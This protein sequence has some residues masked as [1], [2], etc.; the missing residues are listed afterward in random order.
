MLSMPC[1]KFTWHSH[2][3]F[4]DISIQIFCPLMGCLSYCCKTC[5]LAEVCTASILP[6]LCLFILLSLFWSLSVFYAI[7][8][9]NIFSFIKVSAFYSVR[10][11]CKLQ[12]KQTKLY[13][14]LWKLQPTPVLLPRKSR[15]WRSLVQATVHGVAKSWTQLSTFT[16]LHI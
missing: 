14:F 1:D 4:F 7:Q 10:N 2:I 11:L 8:L 12:I 6:Y 9:H 3:F 15:G 16:S 13:G 5:P